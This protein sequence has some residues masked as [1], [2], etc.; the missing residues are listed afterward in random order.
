MTTY[1]YK[2]KNKKLPTY[3]L[4]AIHSLDQNKILYKT[5]VT[6]KAI[7]SNIKYKKQN[8]SFCSNCIWIYYILLFTIPKKV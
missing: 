1:K 2:Q 8:K 6:V 7:S 3:Y 4:D 5:N